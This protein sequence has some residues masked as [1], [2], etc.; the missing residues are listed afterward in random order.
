MNFVSWGMNGLF[1]HVILTS[2]ETRQTTDA[3]SRQ[4]NRMIG[5]GF[6][7]VWPGRRQ[8][9][10]LTR[11]ADPVTVAQ[12]GSTAYLLRN[13]PLREADYAFT[14]KGEAT[15]PVVPGPGSPSMTR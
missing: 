3:I 10:T 13:M 1:V 8:K 12:M 11:Y 7:R 4:M 9:I 5:P 6:A 2:A 14:M 15:V